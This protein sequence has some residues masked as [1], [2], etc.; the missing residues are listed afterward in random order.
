MDTF[1]AV[2][3]SCISYLYT[4]SRCTSISVFASLDGVPVEIT[5]SAIEF[6]ICAINAAIK[7]YNSTIKKKKKRSM[8][9]SFY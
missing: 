4:V 8:I 7:R 5:S 9:K 2:N 1:H 3:D 6:K